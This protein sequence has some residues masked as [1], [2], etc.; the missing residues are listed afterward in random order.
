MSFVDG[1]IEV[2][3]EV[4]PDSMEV[5]RTDPDLPTVVA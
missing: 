2:V 1:M 5:M 3:A 4:L